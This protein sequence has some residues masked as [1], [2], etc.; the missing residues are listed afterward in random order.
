M[1]KRDKNQVAKEGDNKILDVAALKKLANEMLSLQKKKQDISLDILENKN[2][3]FDLG[4]KRKDYNAFVKEICK[5]LDEEHKDGVNELL[6][7]YRGLP[8]FDYAIAPQEEAA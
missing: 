5:P 4:I 8:L 3:A 7:A 6:V 2:K 1:A